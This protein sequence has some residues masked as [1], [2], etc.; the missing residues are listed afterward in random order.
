M[1]FSFVYFE[2]KTLKKQQIKS[3]SSEERRKKHVQIYVKKI[4]S[5]HPSIHFSC[6]NSTLITHKLQNNRTNSRKKKRK[7]LWKVQVNRQKKYD[8]KSKPI[9]AP[10]RQRRFNV[11][12][13]SIDWRVLPSVFVDGVVGFWDLKVMIFNI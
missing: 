7:R 12:S 9:R 10:F 4:Y 2:L 3:T 6:A 11:F 8:S 13:H 5:I 1:F